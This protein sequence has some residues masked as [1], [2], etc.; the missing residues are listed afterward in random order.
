M[1]FTFIFRVYVDSDPEFHLDLHLIVSYLF[2][3]FIENRVLIVVRRIVII[4]ALWLLVGLACWVYSTYYPILLDE[5]L[6]GIQFKITG[7]IMTFFFGENRDSITEFYHHIFI[8]PLIALIGT[9]GFNI[10]IFLGKQSVAKTLY[11]TGAITFFGLNFP[12]TLQSMREL[13]RVPKASR[14]KS[15]E[16]LVWQNMAARIINVFKRDFWRKWW[17]CWVVGKFNMENKFLRVFF[18]IVWI[19]FSLLLV[20]IY[21]LPLFSIWE[22]YICEQIS[23]CT[24]GKDVKSRQIPTFKRVVYVFSMMIQVIGIVMIYV[25]AWDILLLYNQLSAFVVVDLIRHASEHI[26]KLILVFAILA[27]VKGAFL[28]FADKYRELKMGTI[29]GLRDLHWE[30]REEYYHYNKAIKLVF[31]TPPYDIVWEFSDYGEISIPRRFFYEVVNIYRP[32]K[33]YVIRMF[34]KLGA[35]ITIITLLVLLII[36]FQVLDQ[37]NSAGQLL[38]TL[39][40]VS[41][42]LL[43]GG[44]RSP[45]QR[46]LS[47]KRRHLNI[48]AWAERI[49]RIVAEDKYPVESEPH[50]KNND[51]NIDYKKDNES[52][53]KGLDCVPEYYGFK[54]MRVNNMAQRP[55]ISPLDYMVK[56]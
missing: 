53:S 2:L 46:E 4:Y 16:L 22:N 17:K 35:T 38:L 25:M 8:L 51:Y 50:K 9:F 19:P 33:F 41:L 49:S 29:Q 20:G 23:Y 31:L 1:I 7:K 52:N 47:I 5:P 15:Y 32:Y 11:S 39:F 28:N 37:F 42:P 45:W 3:C 13:R 6:L 55:N 54:M 56:F 36:D 24:K 44:I 48:R 26:P 40:T 43:L 34:L 18:L 30:V 27:Y 21:V 14:Y 10:N 12:E